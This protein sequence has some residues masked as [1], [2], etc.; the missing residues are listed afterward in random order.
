[1]LRRLLLPSPKTRGGGT[2]RNRAPRRFLKGAEAGRLALGSL[3]PS[4]PSQWVSS[5]PEERWKRQLAARRGDRP[6]KPTAS[7]SRWALPLD[8][9]RSCLSHYVS[10]F[11]PPP[12]LLPLHFFSLPP[13]S[14]SASLAGM[15]IWSV[16][17]PQPSVR[18]FF[19]WLAV[20]DIRA[21]RGV[22]HFY[23]KQ[24]GLWVL[25]TCGGKCLLCQFLALN[26]AALVLTFSQ[27]FRLEDKLVPAPSSRLG[28]V[29]FADFPLPRRTCP[30]PFSPSSCRAAAP[31]QRPRRGERVLAP[32]PPGCSVLG[33]GELGPVLGEPGSCGLE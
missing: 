33:A 10:F 16:S 7:G 20:G 25:E 9:L 12:F 27:T 14:E 30:H 31:H 32:W 26:R 6:E 5:A 8:G 28:I 21:V 13:F 11:F 29:N 1:M 2:A 15:H 24:K 22:S 23:S 17:S 3:A 4:P 19:C 18:G